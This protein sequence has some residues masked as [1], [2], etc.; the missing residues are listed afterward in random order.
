MSIPFWLDAPAPEYGPLRGAETADVAI[1]GG[2]VTGLA[3]AGFVARAGA[4]VRVLEA[5]RVGSGASGRN[6]GFALRGTAVP[7]DRGRLPELVRMT[8]EALE[9]IADLAGDAFRRVGSL[10]LAVDDEELEALRA[11][12][13]ALAEDGFAAE[14][15][16]RGELPAALRPHAL[17]GVFHPGDGALEQG[18]WIRRL[19]ALAH[20]AGALL[21]EET[22]VRRF[23]DGRVVAEGGTVRA[24][25]VLV[26]TDGY[27]Q[28]LV[29]ELDEAV[30]A[31]RGQVV[32]TEPLGERVVPC[33]IYARWG[34]DYFQQ[35]PD[36]RI[37]AGGRRD[38]DLEGETTR[39]ER[40]TDQVQRRLE[41]LLRDLLGGVP[42]ITHRWAGL[43]GFTRDFLPLVGRLPGREALWASVGYSGHGNVLGFAC[44]EAVGRAMLGDGL[45]ARL[46]ALSPERTRAARPP[47]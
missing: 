23:D 30:V 25:A 46:T 37:V 36:G 32:S 33:P 42:P 14:L 6:G 13:A 43:M 26:A 11:E 44:G 34:Y 7:Y 19:A 22:R 8:E 38:T 2:G 16:A 28:G 4:R 29:P 40:T 18:R 20:E 39:E 47:A 45:D 5:R 41:D 31:F 15:Q 35:L 24:G 10:R 27:T 9:R 1:I 3:C 17:G 21:H 12:H